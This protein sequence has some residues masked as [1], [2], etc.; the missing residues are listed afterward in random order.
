MHIPVA[1]QAQAPPL[2]RDALNMALLDGWQRD[3][4][5]SSRPFATIGWSLGLT[6]AQVIKRLR[7]LHAEG[8]ISRIGAVVRPNTAGASTLAA[9]RVPR[10]RLEEVAALVSAQPE[11]THNYER[12]HDVNL[13][14][15]LTA[16]DRRAVSAALQRIARA[17]GL[18]VL[19]LPLRRAFHI[20]LGFAL[21]GS[22]RTHL[23]HNTGAEEAPPTLEI[24]E[25]DRR[26]LAAIEDGLPLAP[27]PFMEVA[28]WLECS[29]TEVIGRLALLR[30]S[31][32]IRRFGV[33]VR[34]RKLGF[35]ANAMVVWN[36][37]DEL[38]ARAGAVLAQGA[39]VTLCY[40][41]RRQPPEWPYNLFC[42]IHGQARDAVR[43]RVSEL[44]GL[45]RDE[46]GREI[47]HEA[48]F[49]RRCFKQR[50][51]RFSL[52]GGRNA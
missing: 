10:Q 35:C 5:L 42:M 26:L 44:A 9:L 13:W 50:G 38:V 34:H 31:G 48:L 30:E 6:E 24:T 12:E 16:P 23:P 43:R 27:A 40:E 22:G 4:P 52:P 21:P 47:A 33:V 37:P 3:F 2:L 8:F 49:S 46:L 39:G 15:V 45:L 51:A 25:F 19:D 29:E 36:V 41:R 7:K 28:S 18:A 17:T 14:F 11:V 1:K 32:V 20:D